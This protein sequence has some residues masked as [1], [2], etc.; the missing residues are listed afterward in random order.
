VKRILVHAEV[1]SGCRACEVAC[2]AW[3]EGSFGTATARIRVIKIEPLGVDHP[4]VCRLCWRAPCVAAC[5]TGAL[6]RDEGTGAVRLRAGECIGCSACVDACPF[7]MA[8][9]HPETGLALICDLCGGDP[10]CVKRCATGAIVYDDAGAGARAK[11]ER[12]TLH[13]SEH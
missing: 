11:R 12:L 8:A 2:V 10:A 13:A 9:L 3:H 6:Y 4:H 5:P 1:C 7:G